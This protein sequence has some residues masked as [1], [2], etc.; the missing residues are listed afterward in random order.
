[1]PEGELAELLPPEV[2]RRVEAA[3]RAHDRTLVRWLARKLGDP[4]AARD[5]AQSAYLR[6]WS[7][8]A[9]GRIDNL[10]ALLF[11]TAANLAANEFRA[12]RR[13]AQPS[14]ASDGDADDA[15]ENVAADTP[16]PEGVVASR[17]TLAACLHALDGLP[18]AARR[19]FIMS[20]FEELSYAAI[21]VRLGVSESSVEKYMILALK[22]LRDAAAASEGRGA[23][24]AFSAARAR[25]DDR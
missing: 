14:S 19:A 8:S 4:D 15:V 21:A 16:S 11:K 17:Q 23:V 6:I 7:Y 5:V 3:I 10:Q 20:R 18:D 13:R 22:T 24:L 12:R 1:M 25:S 2:R 9:Q